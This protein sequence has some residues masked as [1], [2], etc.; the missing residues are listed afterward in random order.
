[1]AIYAQI[2]VD[3][4]D[5]PKVIEVGDTC[6]LVYV[7]CVLRAR[8]YL[9]DGVIDRRVIAHWCV[10]IR[11]DLKKHAARLVAVGLWELHESG[12]RFPPHVWSQ[13]N[14]TAA[15]VQ[16]KRDEAAARKRRSRKSVTGS[17]HVTDV[18]VTHMSQG[19]HTMKKE[20]TETKP[21]TEKKAEEKP[22]SVM[23]QNES[24]NARPTGPVD[25]SSSR[26]NDV[27]ANY[28][29]IA[30]DAIE[31]RGDAIRSHSGMVRHLTEQCTALA[32]L[33][34]WP[35]MFPTAPAD[36][37]AAWLHG[38][39][40]SM[41]YYPRADELAEQQDGPHDATIHELRPA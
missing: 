2:S 23:S 39:K 30:I 26:R 25:G 37:I 32:Q 13:W 27:I 22:A 40:G 21:E 16:V 29:R 1:M 9:T 35:A 7:R 11:G 14:P 34:Q 4:P 12:W 18:G 17:S 6:E 19:G 10:G 8:R 41:R 33:D 28:V 20:E 31:Q 15:E 3:L 5:D 24:S 36:A 38:D